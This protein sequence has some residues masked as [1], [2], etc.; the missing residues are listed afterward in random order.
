MAQVES[1]WEKWRRNGRLATVAL[2]L[3]FAFWY[4]Y[5]KTTPKVDRDPLVGNM[6]WVMLG[7]WAA[8]IAYGV[9]Q[10]QQKREDK[11]EERTMTAEIRAEAAE[12][13]ATDALDAVREGSSDG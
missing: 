4:Y 11:R 9:Q 13:K 7:G 3:M 1:G 12:S 5:T 6:L 2:V 8:N 10:A